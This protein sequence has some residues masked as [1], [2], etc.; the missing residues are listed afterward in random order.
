MPLMGQLGLIRKLEAISKRVHA[1]NLS[2][3]SMKR[4]GEIDLSDHLERLV[5]VLD[6]EQKI[7]EKSSERDM[8][9]AMSGIWHA[10]KHPPRD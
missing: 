10:L 5:S 8:V 6:A 2:E 1:M 3:D 7:M 9:F 4:I